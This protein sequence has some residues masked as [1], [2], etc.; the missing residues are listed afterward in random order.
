MRRSL[1]C[2]LVVLTFGVVGWMPSAQAV[3]GDSWT[4]RT[5]A[6]A[7]EWT[8][9]TYGNG[10]FVAVSKSGTNNRVMTS[11]DGITWTARASAVDNEWTSVTFGN[12]LFVAV[13]N[14]GAGNRVMTSPDG[15]TWSSRTSAADNSWASVTYGAG[16]FV[17]VANSGAGN[18]VMTSP[19]GIAWTIRVSA[20]DNPWNGVTYRGNLFVA[21]ASSGTS[22]VMTAGTF[23]PAPTITS[24]APNF[25]LVKSTV[26]ITGTNLTAASVVSFNGVA[27]TVF[28]IDSATQ[29]TAK[30]PTGATTG[31]VSVTT[32]GGTATSA[33]SFTVAAS[34]RIFGADAIDTSIAIS[35]AEYPDDGSAASVVLARSDFF[36]DALAGG[37]L[38]AHV[39]GPL[40]ITPGAP[41]T[42]VLDPRVLS[43]INRLLD[44][45]D[46]VHVLGGP[47][48]LSPEI[49]A[50]LT[51][52]GYEVER[53]YGA[54]QFSTAVA[55]A[56]Q[57]G[58]PGAILEATGLN[59]PDALSAVPAAIKLHGVI[60][61][62]NNNVQ[63]P[64]TAAYIAAHPSA[65]RFTI[66][67]PLVAGGA[68][69]N[70]T[71]VFGQNQ[72]GTSAAV[73][74]KWFTGALLYGVAT[75][76]NFPDALS[77]GVFMASG[78]R[79]GAVVLVPTDLPLPTSIVTYLDSLAAGT[80]G[81]AF[82]GPIAISDAVL[83]AVK[84]TVG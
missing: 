7:N 67:G 21:V 4:A 70:A 20:A 81:Y 6:A 63:A 82:G 38:A 18:R 23:T 84:A 71:P 25:G 29:I 10:L 64:E 69:P 62:T 47:L 77:G 37:P 30:V 57:L 15:V 66:G 9:V 49:D 32:P 31:P 51:N 68:D 36:S 58:A 13:A 79:M 50:T 60:V 46:T 53:V 56:N 17:A 22:R 24:F 72:Y 73:A 1:V 3:T 44:P 83:A 19:D 78:G 40:L 34:D 35:K 52:A 80:P 39:N 8:S 45:G 16:L 14:T 2:V 26:V 75:G 59:F 12:G 27:A 33:G 28:T 54:N 5:A 11:P 74:T 43:E 76:A 41:I 55:I 42:S 48:A 65:P 61:L